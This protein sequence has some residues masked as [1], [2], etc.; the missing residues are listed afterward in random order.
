LPPELIAVGDRP[1][2][3]DAGTT[4]VWVANNGDGTVTRIDMEDGETIGDPIEVG[5]SPGAVVVGEGAVWVANNGD[6]TVTRIEPCPP[7]GRNRDSTARFRPVG[8]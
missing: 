1:G 4:T 6:G 3:I 2:G 7:T 8:R 5:P